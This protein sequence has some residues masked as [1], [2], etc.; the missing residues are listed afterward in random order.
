MISILFIKSLL[1]VCM[2][3]MAGI[4]MF[5]MFEMFGRSEKRFDAGK[6][7]KIHKIN[8]IIYFLVFCF[9][10][11]YCLNFII[12]S[13]AELSARGTFHSIF[14][15]TIIVLFIIKIVFL[16]FYRKFY[17]NVK[18]LGILIAI[19]TFGMAGTSAGYYLLVTKL[20][21]DP[22]FDMIM[23]YKKKGRTESAVQTDIVSETL[24]KTDAESIG[25]G[26]TL[27]ETK[28]SFCHDAYSTGTVVGPGLKGLFKN[29]TLPVSGRPATAENVSRQIREPFSRMPSFSYFSDKE[30]SDIITFLNTL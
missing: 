9:I 10:T 6:L 12:S 17:E 19:I 4:A 14:S 23:Q 8:G 15:I 16:K 25:R 13:K 21:S 3:F 30:I 22:T 1:A 7:K 5:T 26:K 11:Y 28:C 27:F 24:I 18:T 20:G 29:E 2:V